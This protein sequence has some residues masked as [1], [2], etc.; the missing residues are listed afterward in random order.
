MARPP[1]RRWLTL[2][3]AITF[4]AEGEALTADEFRERR[5][6]TLIQR[7]NLCLRCLEEAEGNPEEYRWPLKHPGEAHSQ[8]AMIERIPPRLRPP[9]AIELHELATDQIR[10]AEEQTTQR[11]VVE[12]DIAEAK[13]ALHEAAFEGG[14]R[15]SGIRQDSAEQESIPSEYFSRRR[16]IS[17]LENEIRPGRTDPPGSPTWSDVL[18]DR[19][20]FAQHFDTESAELSSR[21]SAPNLDLPPLA[22][23]RPPVLR[24]RV[25]DVLRT[26]DNSIVNGNQESLVSL[27]C[28]RLD[29]SVSRDTVRRAR[30]DLA[31]SDM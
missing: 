9:S 1:N 11:Q 21:I 13:E 25:K 12:A 16:I 20:S 27:V 29:E 14:V 23:G 22:V 4:I 2:T 3:E 18:V 17:F 5:D 19:E 31:R 6:P 24:E 30:Q 8:L 10:L 28:E 15:L 7:I 26:L